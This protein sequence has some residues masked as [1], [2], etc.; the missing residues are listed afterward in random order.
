MFVK[1]ELAKIRG[2]QLMRIV[3]GASIS[4]NQRLD[5]SGIL[6]VLPRSVRRSFQHRWFRVLRRSEQLLFGL[7]LGRDKNAKGAGGKMK[8][9]KRLELPEGHPIAVEKVC[10]LAMTMPFY[11][12][13]DSHASLFTS[14]PLYICSR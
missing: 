7:K 8:L 11:Q 13:C 3:F 10:Y 5:D 9:R 2:Y 6:S 14:S 4:I 1:F 12:L